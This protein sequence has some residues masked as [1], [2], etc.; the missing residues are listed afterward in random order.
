MAELP[1]AERLRKTIQLD[2]IEVARA[3]CGERDVHLRWL[4]QRLGLQLL[5]RGQQFH[6]LG[7]AA[8]ADLAI[9]IL[10]AAQT[11][12]Q[13]G[14]AIDIGTFE[15]LL[16]QMALGRGEPRSLEPL[17]GRIGDGKVRELAT[18]R[19]KAAA[20]PEDGEWLDGARL[21][22]PR[23]EGQRVYVE[24]IRNHDLT[25]GIGPAGS[26]KT[27]L[28]VACALAALQR[29][30]IKKIVL[31]RPAVEAGEHLGFLP[32]D[33]REKVSPY[34]QP[35]H[36]ALAEL[37]DVDKVERL[38]ERGQLEAAPLAFM[39][40]RTLANAFVIVDEAQN[41]TP[42]QLLMVMTRIGEHTKMVITG[43]P[44][45]TDLQGRLVCGLEHAARV[46][47]TLPGVAVVHL[48][49]G[50]VVRHPLVAAIAKAWSEDRE[51]ELRQHH[52]GARP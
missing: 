34:L 48:S 27:W 42:E 6:V 23:S 35:L 12:A 28:A 44:S 1:T 41:C 33:L 26:G 16:R 49:H 2:D 46:T 29:R 21:V 19:R 14:H 3:V 52:R 39:R 51:L 4:E 40:G 37:M 50:D 10:A 45:Q 25:F 15:D 30:E 7:P 8:E 36:D 18:H 5:A 31:T 11:H 9:D 13:R 22:Q 17:G 32:G 47:G 43:D 24:A 20:K 38:M